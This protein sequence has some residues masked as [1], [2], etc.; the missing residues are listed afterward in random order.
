V[1]FGKGVG[2]GVV[3]VSLPL[4]RRP[5]GTGTLSVVMVVF[6]PIHGGSRLHQ[7]VP[8]WA[9]LTC[10]ACMPAVSPGPSPVS[11]DSWQA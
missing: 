6:S 11:P 9:L 5:Q 1:P 10:S 3:Q 2:I 8:S 7:E 4:L